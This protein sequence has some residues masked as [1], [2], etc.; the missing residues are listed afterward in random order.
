MIPRS[1]AARSFIEKYIDEIKKV[2][3]TKELIDIWK[4]MKEKAFLSY[5]VDIKTV[6]ENVNE[7]EEL[8]IENQKKFLIECLD[9]NQLYVNLS[10]IDDTEYE[11][12]KEDKELNKQF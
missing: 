4:T 12:S 3:T 1:S 11:I 2:E 6:D 8:S 7:F 5:K 9:K 10:E